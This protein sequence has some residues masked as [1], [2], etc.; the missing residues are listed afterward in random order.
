MLKKL[1]LG[2]M[3]VRPLILLLCGFTFLKTKNKLVTAF[4]ICMETYDS[5]CKNQADAEYTGPCIDS[6]PTLSSIDIQAQE[7]KTHSK[8]HLM[9]VKAIINHLGSA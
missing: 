8:R 5:P 7:S 1:P 2:S 9:W 4:T 3:G 6:D